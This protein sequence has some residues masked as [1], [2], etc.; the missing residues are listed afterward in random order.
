VRR[1][2]AAHNLQVPFSFENLE[3]LHRAEIENEG[4]IRNS[5]TDIPVSWIASEDAARVAVAALLHPEKFGSDTAV[6]PGAPMQ[7][8]RTLREL[9]APIWAVR[10]AMKISR[11]RRVPF[12]RRAVRHGRP[13]QSRH[14]RAYFC[15]RG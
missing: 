7:Y 13:G 10:C 9:S 4:V 8:N 11:G 2:I 1:P 15:R 12:H 14:G 5:F 3:V 6:Y